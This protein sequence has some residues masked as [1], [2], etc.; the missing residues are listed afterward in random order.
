MVVVVCCPPNTNTVV[1]D[2]TILKR[3]GIGGGGGGGKRLA[4]HCGSFPPFT[5]RQYQRKLAPCGYGSV[6]VPTEHRF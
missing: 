5:P 6:D 2:G 4:E 1:V 3:N